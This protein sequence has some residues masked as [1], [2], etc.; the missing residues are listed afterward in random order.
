MVSFSKENNGRTSWIVE[1]KLL[2]F[3]EQTI[4]SNK[5]FKTIG[6]YLLTIFSN[7]LLKNGCFFHEQSTLMNKRF[8]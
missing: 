1:K 7:N 3:T 8:H 6:F 2:F 4:F 5:L